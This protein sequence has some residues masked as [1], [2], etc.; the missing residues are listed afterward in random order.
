MG[1]NTRAKNITG[2]SIVL[3]LA[4]QLFY[5]GCARQSVLVTK[6]GNCNLKILSTE[7][8]SPAILQAGD[9]V[10]VNFKY[11]MG[12]Y[13]SV[14]ILARP[15]SNGSETPGYKAHGSPVYNKYDG[16]KDSIQ[17][18]FFFDEPAVVDEII[19]RMKDKNRGDYVCVAKKKVNLKWLGYSKKEVKTP[20]RRSTKSRTRKTESVLNLLDSTAFIIGFKPVPPFNPRTAKELLYEFNRNH[21]RGVRTHHFRTKAGGN[22]LRGYICTDDRE[23]LK[24]LVDMLNNRKQLE[25]ISISAVNQEEFEEH[26]RLGQP[27]LLTPGT[28]YMDKQDNSLEIISIEPASPAVLNAGEKLYIN[29]RY[30]LGSS[31]KVQIWARPYTNGNKTRGYNA[32]GS[33]TYNKKEQETGIAQG[34]FFFDEPTK[35]DEIIVQMKDRD[36]GDYV[37]EA[38]K[39]VDVSWLGYSKPKE[40]KADSRQSCCSSSKCKISPLPAADKTKTTFTQPKP[41]MIIEIFGSDELDK[42]MYDTI[43][44]TNSNLI[45]SDKQKDQGALVYRVRSEDKY[46]SRARTEFHW[47]GN[48]R[49]GYRPDEIS[50]GQT[51]VVFDR[52]GQS[53]ELR[54]IHPDYHEFRRPLVFEKGKVIVWDDIFLERVSPENSC[55]VKGTV[56]LEDDADP[57]GIRVSS[58]GTS[59][60]TDDEGNFILKGLRSG[61]VHI[62]AGKSGY[63]G[64]YT[65]VNVAKGQT[66]TCKLNGYRIR[67]AKVRWVYQPDDSKDFTK[68]N[69]VTGTAILQDRELNRVSFA[70]GFKQVHGKSDFFVHQVGGDLFIM[71]TDA[72]SGDGPAFIETDISFDEITKVPDVDF[73]RSTRMTLK[74]GKVYI[75]RCYDGQHYAKMEVLEIID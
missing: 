67:K 68:D 47:T 49:G 54:V 34:W 70:E 1:K 31:E 2:F 71:N 3:L 36:S 32:H 60:T 41:N 75:F 51:K 12:D 39:K 11:D 53:A 26:C 44:K 29:F 69:I 42:E 73:R 50:E 22:K 10:Y 38:K 27:S 64:L 58:G 9:K 63:Y 7:P 37:C 8:K 48:R 57:K 5:C 15:R 24:A 35:V 14:Q 18:Y 45:N 19:V 6:Q 25:L 4:M 72:R 65:T 55:T 56:H 23:D 33:T 20:D 28:S 13:D 46:L 17:G 40:V 74:A 66:A 59:A 16:A 62:G 61:E 21:P 52:D 43:A 30:T